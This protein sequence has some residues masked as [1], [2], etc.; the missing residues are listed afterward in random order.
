M[1]LS[2]YAIQVDEC[3][4]KFISRFEWVMETLEKLSKKS[5]NE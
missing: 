5:K 1:E 3:V 4:E 2:A